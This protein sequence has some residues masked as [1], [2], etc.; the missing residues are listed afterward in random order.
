L[1]NE[2]SAIVDWRLQTL[3]SDEW[4]AVC[5]AEFDIASDVGTFSLS[6]RFCRH[7]MKELSK[8]DERLSVYFSAVALLEVARKIT[9]GGFGDKLVDVLATVLGHFVDT[10]RY[11]NRWISGISLSNATKL[12]KVV[13]NNSRSTV[14]LIQIELCK[15]YLQRTLICDESDSDSIYCLSN[16]YLAILY[17]ITGQYETAID[18]C[19]LVTTSQDHSQCSSHV[20]QGE[21]LPKIHDD[22]DYALGLAVFYQHVRATAFR[23]PH[24]TLHFSVFTTPLIRSRHMAL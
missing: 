2:V 20:V 1:Q 15:A 18:R 22:V 3:L 21:L 4:E 24:Q 9:Q 11:F 12:M 10:P 23:Q 19:T 8:V 17:C 7:S 14:Q 5:Q 13:A 16:V 6:V